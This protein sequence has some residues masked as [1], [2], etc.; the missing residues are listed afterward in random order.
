MTSQSPLAEAL[1]QAVVHGDLAALGPAERTRYYWEVCRSLGLN[2]LTRPFE[3]LRL[4][5]RLVL[6]ATRAAADQLRARHG[7]SID[8]PELR[9]E[10]GLAIWTVT[11]RTRDGRTDSDLGV[12]PLA[13]LTG[14]AKANA[15]MR[16]LTKAKR[17]VTLSLAG[18]GWLDETEVDSVPGAE[19]VPLEELPAPPAGTEEPDVEAPPADVASAPA[20]EPL[21]AREFLAKVRAA[22]WSPTQVRD[23]RVAMYP[24]ASSITDLTDAE[25]GALLRRLQEELG[26]A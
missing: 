22:G 13:G 7:I 10:E 20:P 8:R 23:A 15:L 19:R 2:P 3:F 12:V 4:N 16:G 14:D 1:E 25:R 17:R 24:S 26:G 21:S 9:I 5:G 6:Y 18:L 11:A